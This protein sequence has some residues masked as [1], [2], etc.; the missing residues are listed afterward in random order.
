[1]TRILSCS[2]ACVVGLIFTFASAPASAQTEAACKQEYAARKTAGE[3]AGETQASYVK[4][5]LARQ[6][7]AA[8]DDQ[9]GS[10]TDA[11]AK[12]DTEKLSSDDLAKESQNP[13][14][15]LYIIPFNNYTTLSFRSTTT[16]LSGLAPTAKAEAR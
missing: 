12:H 2:Q 6:P 15:N 7:D 3:T 4:P 14:G 5:C 10:R 16:R 11:V 1:M 9:G 8:A 13:V